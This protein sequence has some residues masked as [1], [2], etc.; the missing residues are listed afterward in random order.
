[1]AKIFNLSCNS[2]AF[3]G[4]I[5][6]NYEPK[7][8]LG[9]PRYHHLR[10]LR[11]S[12]C[13]TSIIADQPT[14]F[15]V[16]YHRERPFWIWHDRHGFPGRRVCIEPWFQE[17][18]PPVSTTYHFQYR[19]SFSVCKTGLARFASLV[20]GACSDSHCQRALPQLPLLPGTAPRAFRRLHPLICSFTTILPFYCYFCI[21]NWTHD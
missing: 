12:L 2:V 18:P 14:G 5:C 1:M 9:R 4:Y 7:H 21:S 16:W 8:K 17:T 3:I 19:H 15:R 13:C 11:H 10:S 20:P 6:N